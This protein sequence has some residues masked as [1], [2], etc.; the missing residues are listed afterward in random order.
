MHSLHAYF[1]RPGDPSVPIV[2][3]VDQ[4]RDG[5]SFTTRRVVAV[6]RGKA[7]FALSASFQEPESGIEHAETMPD[8]P[9]PDEL[10]TRL[11]SMLEVADKLRGYEEAA[12]YMVRR[13]V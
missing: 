4:I 12:R 10:P 11:D 9:P 13:L 7:I 3:E 5:R 1:I 2:Y 6:Q 8:V